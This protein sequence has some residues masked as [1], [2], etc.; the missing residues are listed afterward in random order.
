[1]V[2]KH[3]LK[4]GMTTANSTRPKSKLA[5][6]RNKAKARPRAEARQNAMREALA[7]GN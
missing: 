6:R 2:N 7:K 5:K 1:M 4:H 3:S